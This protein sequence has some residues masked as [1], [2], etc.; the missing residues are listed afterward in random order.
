MVL[1]RTNK[2]SRRFKETRKILYW[3]LRSL[4]GELAVEEREVLEALK[5]NRREFDSDNSED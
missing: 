2:I 5:R 1:L 4:C 3:S